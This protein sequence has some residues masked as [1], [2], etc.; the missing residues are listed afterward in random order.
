MEK[1]LNGIIESAKL[2]SK[3]MLEAKSIESSMQEKSGHANFVTEYDKR[4][5]ACLQEE[6]AKVVPEA[7]F[8]GEEDDEHSELP[9]GYAFIVDPIDGTT[10]FM[11]GYNCSCISIAL[12]E[13]AIPIIG[14]IY[15]P[16]ADE[17]FTA[18]KGKG[19][20]L[21]GKAIHVRGEALAD[22]VVIVGTAPYYEELFEISFKKIYKVFRSCLDIRRSGSAAIDLC[23]VAAGRAG[24][25]F[26]QEL[27]PWDYAAGSLIVTEAGGE[28][29]HIDG[30]SPQYS[31]K[32]GA[33]AGSKQTVEEYFKVVADI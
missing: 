33:V 18:I 4:V 2:A 26:E 20:Y 9:E 10:N 23:N 6:L 31:E 24:L 13:N 21:N 29:V 7:V 12:L 1:I 14:V 27:C 16:Y 8:I 19:A 17:M 5:Q 28:F 32:R 11:M 22:S 3:I 15:N 25:Y 30:S